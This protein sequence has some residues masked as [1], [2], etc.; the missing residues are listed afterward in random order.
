M[1]NTIGTRRGSVR[2]APPQAY[3]P[4]GTYNPGM[5]QIKAAIK[6]FGDWFKISI[7]FLLIVFVCAIFVA[8]TDGE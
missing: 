5:E 6:F 7:I 3:V 4:F 2:G 1:A 8:F